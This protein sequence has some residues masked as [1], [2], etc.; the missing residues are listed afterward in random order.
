MAKQASLLNFFQ[1]VTS[2]RAEKP[3]TTVNG[4]ERK[5]LNESSRGERG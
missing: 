4:E 1:K 3:H 5:T 2:P